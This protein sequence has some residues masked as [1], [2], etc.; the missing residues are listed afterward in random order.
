M[1]R[2]FFLFLSI[3]KNLSKTGKKMRII[4]ILK[5]FAQLAG[6]E[7]VMSDKI[8]YLADHH[9]HITLITYE[10]GDHPLAFSLNP[11]VKHIDLKTRFFT[12]SKFPLFI[13]FFYYLKLKKTFRSRL[14]EIIKQEHPDYIVTTTYS[15]KV[16]KD[17]LKI[18]KDAKTII[19][20]HISFHSILRKNDF[21]KGS[22]THFIASIYDR[23]NLNTIR[24]FDMLVSLTQQD[25]IQWQK[26]VK[27][28][29]IIPNPVTKY[30]ESISTKKNVKHRIIAVGRL[31]HQKGFSRLIQAFS[32]ISE[33][34]PSWRID[35]F[36]K[37]ELYDELNKL[38]RQKGLY[39]K[40][41]INQP[42]TEIYHEYLNS[43]FYVLSSEYEGFC[44]VM[45]EAMACGLPCVSFDCPY[46]PKEL[47]VS[48]KNGLLVENGNVSELA[49]K[50]EWMITHDSERNRMS[51]EARKT[52]NKY[53]L[54]TIMT[55]W[56]ELFLNLRK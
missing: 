30:P 27:N 37:G 10:Q 45:L 14:R 53:K 20:S 16:A 38:I 50:I 47:I 21:K 19:E 5:S 25:S 32:L 1:F 28:V 23:A 15:L 17:I 56:E 43:D 24:K 33:K 55:Q 12:L 2:F 54:D 11:S 18:K 51:N 42:T 9:N 40:V 46:G 29:S 22:I 13:R 35:I 52:I 36:G 44:L 34:Y 39:E 26:F 49:Q 8:N 4:Y 41:S 48:G 3:I 31:N 6:V 7:R